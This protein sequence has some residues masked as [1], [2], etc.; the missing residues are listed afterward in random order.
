MLRISFCC[1]TSI[2]GISLKIGIILGSDSDLQEMKKCCDVLDDFEM[3]YELTIS[4]AH[5]L[6]AN[7]ARWTETAHERGIEVIIAAAGMA[8]AL[9]GVVAGYTHL[10]VI[11]VP[12]TSKALDGV[13]ALYS[14]V[15]MPPGVPVATVAI[16]GSRN[17]AYLAMRILGVKYSEISK[18]VK[19]HK[20]QMAA[21]ALEVNER[22][23]KIGID[24]Y[25][26][27]KNK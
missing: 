7:T 8:A 3:E 5:R 27:E 1:F 18:K 22:I 17:A 14:I 11:G 15:Q 26:K 10:P 24:L 9:P 16:N 2:G 6:P 12:L 20:A 19:I 25:L 4:S 13:D 21:S 23:Q